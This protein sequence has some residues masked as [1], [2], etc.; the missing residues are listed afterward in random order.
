MSACSQQ[1]RHKNNILERCF[2]VFIVDLEEVFEISSQLT[3]TCSN[4]AIEILE[5]VAKTC[6]KLTIKAPERVLGKCS[7]G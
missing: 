7:L 6:S 2:S 5:K 3:F 4:S 1:K